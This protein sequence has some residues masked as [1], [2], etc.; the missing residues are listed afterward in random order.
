M[1]E[2]YFLNGDLTGGVLTD[3]VE[4]MR[5]FNEAKE[6]LIA[7]AKED[8]FI[9]LE[10]VESNRVVYNFL[11]KDGKTVLAN[12]GIVMITVEM[13]EDFSLKP[14]TVFY[15]NNVSIDGSEK[16]AFKTRE[17]AEKAAFMSFASK[18]AIIDRPK[19]AKTITGQKVID[20]DTDKV[21]Y[22]SSTGEY[23]ISGSD[24]VLETHVTR[25]SN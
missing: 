8:P 11:S 9:E 21:Y 16:L 5:V 3:K 18:V 7:V 14:G 13:A 1:K 12:G 25:S 23:K 19:F 22:L 2:L 6:K 24:F 4:A 10:T 20:L 17:K 15:A